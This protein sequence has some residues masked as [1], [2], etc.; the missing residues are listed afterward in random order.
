MA[1][2]TV[3]LTECGR[4]SKSAQLDF[5]SQ[6]LVSTGRR[7]SSLGGN[8]WVYIYEVV[9]SATPQL[10]C[11]SN[12]KSASTAMHTHTMTLSYYYITPQ[13]SHLYSVV[14]YNVVK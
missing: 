11:A 14:E 4:A 13:I 9:I 3:Y 2:T 8:L 6:L 10:L 1:G 7:E 12:F 5:S